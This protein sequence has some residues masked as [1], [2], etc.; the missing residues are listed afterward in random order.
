MYTYRSACK[1]A[2]ILVGF[3]MKLEFSGKIFGKYTNTKFHE[4]PSIGSRVVPSGQTYRRTV[5][6]KLTV[7]F[8]NFANALNNF[9]KEQTTL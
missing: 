1:I 4:N 8:R 2:V 5:M 7:A 9:R 6:T 3:L